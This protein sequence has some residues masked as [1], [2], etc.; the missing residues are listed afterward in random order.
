MNILYVFLSYY[1]NFKPPISN[2]SLAFF[3]MIVFRYDFLYDQSNFSVV[4]I[5]GAS[6]VV[7]VYFMCT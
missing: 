7:A 2:I 6:Y 4:V 3:D 5:S 1:S